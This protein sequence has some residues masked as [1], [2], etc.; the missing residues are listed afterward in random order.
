MECPCSHGGGG[1]GLG[2]LRVDGPTN[3]HHMFPPQL[4]T[5]AA[6]AGLGVVVFL[7]RV[8]AAAAA[9]AAALD[10]AAERGT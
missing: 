3:I 6:A 4:G 9:A 2:G 10:S 8:L 5:M 1:Q 7:L